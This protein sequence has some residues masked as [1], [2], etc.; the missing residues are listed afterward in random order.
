MECPA[1]RC[2]IE[3]RHSSTGALGY[4]LASVVLEFCEYF[5]PKIKVY[6]Y[7]PHRLTGR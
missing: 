4:H 6:A 2:G 3:R 7:D 1:L 5:G